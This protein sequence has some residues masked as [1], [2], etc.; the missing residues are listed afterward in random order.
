MRFISSSVFAALVAAL[1]MSAVGAMPASAALP[2]FNKTNVKFTGVGSSYPHFYVGTGE[3][4]CRGFGSI[5]GEIT[6]AKSLAGVVVKFENCNDGAVCYAYLNWETEPLGGTLG[7]INKANKTLGL[8]LAPASG[9]VAKCSI[10]AEE[11]R[12]S[13]IGE[14]KPVNTRTTK[15][16]LSFK[17]NKDEQVL[18][19]FEGEEATHNLERVYVGEKK[20]LKAALGYE[21]NLTFEKEVEIV[22]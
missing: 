3:S 7:Y 15:F 21:V 2:E 19:K 18:K 6:G 14:I 9:P 8:L 11:L 13:I 16:T 20:G 5:K 1:I 4:S 17:A 22:A 10:E 12:G